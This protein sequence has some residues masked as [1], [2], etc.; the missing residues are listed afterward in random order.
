MARQKT[1]QM[2]HSAD[3]GAS[4][5]TVCSLVHATNSVLSGSSSRTSEQAAEGL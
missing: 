2:L 4:A 1:D 5:M 3:S